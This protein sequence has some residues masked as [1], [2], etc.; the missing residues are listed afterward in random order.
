[1]FIFQF[2]SSPKFYTGSVGLRLSGGSGSLMRGGGVC[3]SLGVGGTG[4]DL[5][6]RYITSPVIQHPPASRSIYLSSSLHVPIFREDY[7]PGAVHGSTDGTSPARCCSHDSSR[8]GGVMSV[9]K[10]ASGTYI[11]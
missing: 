4:Y 9:Y 7:F 6:G 5:R 1:M 3:V 8:L 11:P 2:V 10:R